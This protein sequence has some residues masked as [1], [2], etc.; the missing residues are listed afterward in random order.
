MKKLFLNFL[1][2][3]SFNLLAQW[4]TNSSINSPVALAPK[5][6]NS[7]HSISDSNGGII[8]VW[9]DN[10]NSAT[11]QDDIY[12]QRLNASGIR[13]WT[14]YGISI[15]NNAGV[16][17]NSSVTDVGNGNSII[18]WQDDRAGNYDIYAQKIDSSGNILW[19]SNGVAVCSKTTAQKSPKIVDDNAGGAYIVWEDSL[20][21]Y[22]DIYAQHINSNGTLAWAS[23]GVSIC[24][25]PN[26]QSNPRI[27][28]DGLGGAIITWQDK[29][30]NFDYDIYAQRINSSGVVQWTANGVVVCNSVNT[31]SNPRIEPDGSNGA[32]IGWVDKRNGTDNDIYAQRINSSGVV[33]WTANGISVCGAT[34]N[35]S[36][37]D[38]KYVGSSGLVLSWK[39]ERIN[40]NEIYT[41]LVSLSGIAQLAS[42]GIKLSNALKSLS[43]NVIS[44]GS[45]GAIIAWQDST[46]LGWDITSQ[47]INSVG[48][49]QWAAGGVSVTNAND[50]Q[51]YVSQVHDGNGGAIF[52]WEDHR[53]G[54]DYDIYAHHLYNNG[55]AIVGIKELSS[56]L[57]ET[58]CYP[59][60]I[61]QHSII[62]IS[63]NQTNEPWEITIYD[64]C[65]QELENKKLTA[66][67]MYYLNSDTYISGIYFYSIRLASS[68]KYSK[69]NFISIK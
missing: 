35:Q 8:M 18:T 68:N 19:T 23:G 32:L 42:N 40:A 6:Q 7:V 1:I 63:N 39:D 17:K 66:D 65:G 2:F 3:S 62:K 54:T 5:S 10:R 41:Q 13:K 20:N 33:Q 52:A 21:F 34:N 55:T 22:W 25:A 26:L 12:A 43:P 69:G 58:Q 47:K 38:M 67:E 4:S 14:L 57:I 50:D 51:L 59:N 9:D 30:N 15:C 36:A 60:P 45:G 64:S 56:A 61:N 44:D 27:D 11:T 46:A 28:V 24:S 53:N 31:Q 49:I 48:T 37:I 16:Q 29:R